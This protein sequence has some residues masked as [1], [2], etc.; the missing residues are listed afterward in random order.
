MIYSDHHAL[1]K[2][3]GKVDTGKARINTRL[4]RL[5]EFNLQV[6]HA[7]S[8]DQHIGLADGLSRMPTDS[9]D[10]R[11]QIMIQ[12]V[13]NNQHSNR[14]EVGAS[15]RAATHGEVVKYLHICYVRS[16]RRVPFTASTTPSTATWLGISI[17]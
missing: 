11:Q 2:I 13:Y 10:L 1:S 17:S 5:S 4:D 16:P 8:R 7:L 14:S 9:F 12:K 3:F 6:A 15:S